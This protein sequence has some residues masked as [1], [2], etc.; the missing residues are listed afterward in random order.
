M[1]SL[2]M[3]DDRAVKGRNPAL[4]ASERDSLRE[5]IDFFEALTE[6]LDGLVDYSAVGAHVRIASYVMLAHIEGR[7]VT[8]SSA[9]AASG[10]P[11]A[12]GVRRLNDLV[13]AGF[14]DQRPRSKSG[15]TFTVHPSDK[16]IERWTE[17][18][19]RLPRLATTTLGLDRGRDYYFSSSYSGTRLIQ[20]PRVLP[21][22][23]QL[24][25][26]VRILVHADPTFMVMGN[27]KRQ[28]EQLVGTTIHQR[29]F[30]ID[31]LRMEA[32]RNA[33]RRTS[34]YDIVAVDLPWIGE[35]AERG[36]LLP[37]GEIMDVARLQ[38]DDF[39]QAGWEAAHWN[40]VPY[41]V[42]NQTTPELLFYRTDLFAEAGLAPPSTAEEVIEAAAR[43]HRPSRGRY[44]IAWNAARGTAVGHTF[45]MTCAAFGQ[46]ILDL[47]RRGGSFD[48]R[49]LAGRPLRP[50]MDTARAREAAD[51]L[52]EL[53]RFSPPDILS[54]SWYERV[55]PYAAGK[56]AMAYGYT[57]L[58][59]YF[60]LDAAS[61]AARA[62]GFLPHPSGAGAPNIAPVGGYVL[63]IPANVAPERRE[64]V[65]AA[66]VLLTSA[67]ACKLYLLNG[68]LVTPR[69]SVSA[70]P[71]VRRLSPLVGAVDEM[72]RAGLLQHWPRPPAPEISE[73][74]AICG[75]ELHDMLR[76]LVSI[77]DA[78]TR[79]QNR[80]DAL[81]RAA[82]HY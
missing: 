45:M 66:L 25:G 40:G 33:E 75:E 68:S 32:L 65:E 57:L 18:A 6:E 39:H 3:V 21:Q 78:L 10:A 77:E 16:L 26:G 31:R 53:M 44:G 74:I 49:R 46:P 73:V 8:P 14:I 63:G 30:S 11:Y 35:F 1:Q 59:P 24:A 71:E 50:M 62:T 72:A 28:F 22:P 23:L 37:L 29:A 42:P 70:D 19:D 7:Q 43:F 5:A 76:G 51:Y 60:E 61:P 15:K 17:F 69:F 56:V 2:A 20:P 58:A 4:F 52:L 67:E 54:M 48:A 27:L 79:A 36:V 38:P 34:R 13:E 81:M 41:G 47:P 82:G 80:A 55:R 64:D 12:T 9:V